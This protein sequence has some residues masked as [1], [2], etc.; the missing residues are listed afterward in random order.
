MFQ[1]SP[2]A[3]Q[4]NLFHSIQYVSNV[5]GCKTNRPIP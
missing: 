1:M 5:P 3:K 2:D 4:T